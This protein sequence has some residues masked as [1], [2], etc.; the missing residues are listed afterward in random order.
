MNIENL[1]LKLKI[2]HNNEI[3]LDESTFCGMK[4]KARFI[5]KDCGEWWQTPSH[6]VYDG[7]G[8]PKKRNIKIS[9]SLTKLNNINI[10]YDIAEKRNGKCL[11]FKVFNARTLLE[12]KCKNNHTW[13]QNLNH[14]LYSKSWC[15]HCKYIKAAKTSN[16]FF[17]LNHWKSNE[18]VICTASYEK[19]VVEYLNKNKIKYLWQPKTFIISNKRSYRPDLYLIDKGVWI[20]IKGYFRK[21]AQEKWDWFHKQYIN[22]ELWDKKKLKE[23]G[24][25]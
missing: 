18:E 17:I 19:R 5:D 3:L 1:K 8:H 6:V 4:K 14:I 10:A 20:E 7:S 9:K 11:S 15:P 12:W 23:M 2:I 16:N 24:I 21:D 13:K 25:L 22:S